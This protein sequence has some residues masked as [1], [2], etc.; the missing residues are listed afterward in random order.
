M[1]NIWR[2][3]IYLGCYTEFLKASKYFNP[4]SKFSLCMFECRLCFWFQINSHGNTEM[5]TYTRHIH[6]YIYTHK[7][8]LRLNR[9]KRR[10]Y[11]SCEYDNV[12][13][14][15]PNPNEILLCSKSPV[16][17]I[18]YIIGRR[19]HFVGFS[20]ITNKEICKVLVRAVSP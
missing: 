13:S 9:H 3:L 4:F 1:R 20:S 8:I 2:Y 14:T 17:H 6:I 10:N 5:H 16:V 12:C 18:S 11:L 15:Q 19:A 7:H